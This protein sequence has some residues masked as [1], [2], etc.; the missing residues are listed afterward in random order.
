MGKK[1][2]GKLVIISGPSGSGKTTIAAQ[3]V[4]D[5]Q[6]VR[7]ISVTTRPTRPGE[8]DGIDYFFT[9]VED[10][11]REIS[12]G[13]FIEFTEYHGHLY[14]THVKPLEEALE[15]GLTFL[16]VIELHGAL[17]IKKLYPHDTISFFILPPDMETLRKRLLGRKTD[18]KE[19]IDERM[20]FA[21]KEMEHKS[22]YDNCLINEDSKETVIKIKEIIKRWSDGVKESNN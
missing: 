6:F 3:L 16:L 7:S 12:E 13:S 17:K 11:R 20:A 5:H 19:D 1:K 9:S 4:K 22:V 10:F 18:T 8:I 21:L 14:G 15:K 2:Y